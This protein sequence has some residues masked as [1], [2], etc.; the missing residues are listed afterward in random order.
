MGKKS[1]CLER[2]H[3][4]NLSF[5][6]EVVSRDECEVGSGVVSSVQAAQWSDRQSNGGAAAPDLDWKV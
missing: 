5:Q 6:L 1:D 2:S 3:G 4:M